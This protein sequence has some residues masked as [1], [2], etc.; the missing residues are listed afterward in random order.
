MAATTGAPTTPA[1]LGP[2]ERK[3]K[4]G[5]YFVPTPDPM[6]RVTAIRMMQGAVAVLVFAGALALAG[7]LVLGVLAGVA[8][9]GALL[10]PGWIKLGNYR[11]D[12]SRAEP[13]AS[14]D[15]VDA[16][17]NE[18]L[19]ATAADALKRFE[20]EARELDLHAEDVRPRSGGPDLRDPE[21]PL[22][23]IAPTLKARHRLGED[24]HRRF[25]EYTVAV[26]CPGRHHLAV[27]TCELNVVTGKRA[28]NA[29]F[30]YHY[31]HISAVHT[32]GGSG[33][34]L[35]LGAVPGFSTL[36]FSPSFL[37]LEIAATGGASVVIPT[38]VR[39]TRGPLL[40]RPS[41]V[42][43]VLPALRRLL[44]REQRGDGQG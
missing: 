7:S 29:T 19:V 39:H 37:E 26:L 42:E 22:V 18:D 35:R 1:P 8:A 28:K 4:I 6:D 5:K 10:L 21:G 38:E 17:L 34:E 25:S 2:N 27:L 3:D 9:I 43:R 15:Q 11:L 23:L 20:L 31:D 24:R 36:P 33:A 14:D 40:T 13:K 41:T 12:H 30:E 16:T 32:K 44:R